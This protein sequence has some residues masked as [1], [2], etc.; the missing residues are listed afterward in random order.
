MH[1]ELVLNKKVAKHLGLSFPT[2]MLMLADG[3]IQ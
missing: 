2:A 1:L 3:V